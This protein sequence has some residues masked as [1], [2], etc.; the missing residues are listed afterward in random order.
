MSQIRVLHADD[1]EVVRLSLKTLLQQHP[2]LRVVAEAGTGEETV[3]QALEHCPDV[4]VID[5]RIPGL[6]GIDACRQI[7]QRLPDTRVI[8]LTTFAEQELLFAAIRAGASGYVLRRIAGDELV[9]AIERVASGES[10]LD[11]AL[12]TAVFKEVNQREK[13]KESSVFAVL[14]SQELRVLVLIG[15]GLSNREI[16][17]RLFLGEHTVRNNV[18][19]LL[20]KLNLSNRAEAA[21]FAAQH[22][23]KDHSTPD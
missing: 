12:T 8:V 4:V 5:S 16:A 1:H 21:A 15:D 11:P 19:S 17:G 9:R 2:N 7:V 22:H 3:R 13:S 6:S 18:S 20:N 23:A 14:S 10:I